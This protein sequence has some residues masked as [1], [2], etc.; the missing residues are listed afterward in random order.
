MHPNPQAAM[1]IADASLAL[2][3]EMNYPPG[4]AQAL[5]IIGELARI[6]GDDERAKRA[7]EECLAVCQE[8]GE[9]L[10]T[11]YNLVNLAYV[12]QHEGDH[13]QALRLVRRALQIT[14]DTGDTRD[15]AAFLVTLAGSIAALGRHRRAAQ[16]LGASEAALERMGALVQPTDQ[17]EIDRI[18][19]ELQAQLDPAIF[20]AARSEGR[21]M[22]L[23]MAM[24]AALDED[25]SGSASPRE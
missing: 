11:C 24:A 3:R 22:T 2:F 18:I 5:N 4:V 10:R 12:A 17:P 21:D 1:P 14:R 9:A 23:E 15:V 19:T 20:Q 7:Y 16:L 6:S 13:E 25:G 8:T